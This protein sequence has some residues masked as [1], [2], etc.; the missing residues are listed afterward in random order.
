MTRRRPGFRSHCPV[1]FGLDVFGDQWSLL[2]VRDI[3][4]LERRTFQD[5]LSGGEGIATNVL[6]DRLA[7]LEE[8]GILTR[9]R[10][11]GDRRR[12]AYFLT[13]RG[14]DL[15]PVLIEMVEWSSKHDPKSAAT[16]A[17][18]SHLRANRERLRTRLLELLEG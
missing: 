6:A 16:R 13:K 12:W 2:I 3:M 14:I 7:R 5:F 17:M 4:L 11:P 15:I 8:A 1:S 10:D 9:R 18:V